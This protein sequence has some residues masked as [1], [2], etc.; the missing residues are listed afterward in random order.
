MDARTRDEFLKKPLT[1]VLSTTGKDGRIHAIPVWYLWEDGVFKILTA[2]KSQKTRNIAR[3]GR[4]S[5]C[6]DQRDRGAVQWITAEGPVEIVDTVTYEMRLALW[7][8]YWGAEAEQRLERAGDN[9]PEAVCLL[10]KPEH[11][12]G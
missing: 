6:I 4:A 8:N 5:L 11:W 10:L 7:R 12:T 2:R 9:T 3:T 1:A